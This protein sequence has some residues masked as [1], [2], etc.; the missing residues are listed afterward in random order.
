MEQASSATERLPIWFWGYCSDGMLLRSFQSL[1]PMENRSDERVDRYLKKAD[2]AR[3][4]SSQ[5]ERQEARRSFTLLAAMWTALARH[6]QHSK[7]L[8]DP[9]Q[10]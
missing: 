4:L 7:A 10:S 8:S 3:T 2:E 5:I 1:L 6:T 9:S